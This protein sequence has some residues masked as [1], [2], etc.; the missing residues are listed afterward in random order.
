MFFENAFY[1]YTTDRAR[2]FSVRFA[3]CTLGNLTT[4]F[5]AQEGAG[6]QLKSQSSRLSVS[7][8][9]TLFLREQPPRLAK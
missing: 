1:S 5:W 8:S 9:P 4:E 7:L 6:Q 2:L 3:I